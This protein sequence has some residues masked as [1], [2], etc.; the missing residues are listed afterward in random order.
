VTLEAACSESD[1]VS[2]RALSLVHPLYD[3]ARTLLQRANPLLYA[4]D[5]EIWPSSPDLLKA[6]HTVQKVLDHLEEWTL[7]WRIPVLDFP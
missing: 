3:L 5:F 6:A 4:D 2:L 7:K 1:E